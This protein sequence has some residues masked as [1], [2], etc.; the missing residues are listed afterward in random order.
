MKSTVGIGLLGAGAMGKAHSIAFRSVSSIFR[1]PLQPRLVVV[2]DAS[3]E[4]AAR[5]AADWGFERHAGDWRAVI[6]DPDVEIVDIALPNSLHR[7]VSLAAIEAGKFVYCEKPMAPTAAEAAEMLGAAERAGVATQVGFNF[8]KNPVIDLAREIIERGEIGEIWS[9]S[10]RH[11]EDYMADPGKPWTWR[12]DPSGG[13]GAV[14]DLGSHIV[15]MARYLVGPI[16]EVCAVAD[17]VVR[18]RPSAP[19]SASMAP[20]KVDDLVKALVRFERGCIGTIEAS[21]VASGRKMQLEFEIVGSKG[22]L[23]FSQ[24]RL[25]EL[26]LFQYGQEESRNGFRTIMAG[27]L[28]PPYLDF[29]IAGG[30]Q[31]GYNDLKTI[32]VRDVILAYA[33]VASRGPDFREGWAVQCVV[34]A[35]IASIRTRSW[36]AVGQERADLS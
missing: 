29:C 31:L 20:V 3:E 19:G 13:G 35:I 32:E 9:F 17:T 10:G 24:A 12:L 7:E 14:A 2:A 18:S 5:A 30:H 28:H 16:V 1:L 6:D 11:A 33:G 27:P 23:A 26:Q 8:L 21:W 15:S 4:L 36:Q 22:T 34:D 25:S